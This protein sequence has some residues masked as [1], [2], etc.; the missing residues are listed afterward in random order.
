MTHVG[1]FPFGQPVKTVTQ[2]S[3]E[4]RH[5]FI[6]GAYGSAVHARWVGADGKTCIQALAV[7]SEPEIF[8]TGHRASE[9]IQQVAIPEEAGC[10]K[11]A[12]PRLNGPSGKALDEYYLKPLGTTRAEAWLC[13]LV[14]HSCMNEGQSRALDRAYLPL[15]RELDLPEVVWPRAPSSKAEWLGLVD[16]RRRDQ[17]A[18]ELEEA[19]PEVLITLGD[20]PLRWFTR[21]FGTLTSLAAY[22][23]DYGRLLEATI[24]G[25]RLLLLPLAHPHQVAQLGRSSRKWAEL[26]RD[27]M[28][29]H[30][31]SLLGRVAQGNAVPPAG[32]E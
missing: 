29:A 20:Y 25:C 24:A 27:W 19:S 6:L 31:S 32:V 28:A 26:H 7:A 18:S 9:L 5:V 4:P 14:P 1:V 21:R 30:A 16:W 11:P 13:D 23:H 3:R 10:L 15:V 8:W 12:A 2:L 17:I 22:G